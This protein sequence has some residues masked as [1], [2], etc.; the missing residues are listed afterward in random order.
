MIQEMIDKAN[1][2]K[3]ADAPKL[4]LIEHIQDNQIKE[5]SA[6]VVGVDE[7]SLSHKQAA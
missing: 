7:D 4:K 5:M 3:A 2:Q 1:E 6:Y